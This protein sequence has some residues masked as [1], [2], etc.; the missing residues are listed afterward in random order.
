MR[1]YYI[2]ISA[3]VL[4]FF[5]LIFLSQSANAG[6]STQEDILTHGRYIATIAGC[7]SCHTPDKA[8]YQNPK[9]LTPEMIQTL[10]FDGENAIDPQKFL[11]GGRL[12]DLGPAGVV[13]SRNLTSDDTTGT[14]KWTDEQIKIAIKT[15]L[16]ADGKTLFPVMPYHVFTGMADDD[17]TAVVAFIRSVNAVNN[18]V[19]KDTVKT[20]GL[21]TLP[22]KK[23]I[24]APDPS[25][26]AAR[27]AYLV[28]N[29]MACNDCHTP[30]DPATGAP[31]AEKYLAGGQP[32]EGPWGIVYGGN[33]TPDPKTGLGDW[34][35]EQIK[36]TFT[37]GIRKDGRRLILL[38]WYAYQSL[39]PQ[40]ADA[41]AYYLKHVLPA[42][43]NEVPAASLKPG[44]SVMTPGA[45]AAKN[46]QGSPLLIWIIIG[47]LIITLAGLA[48]YYY[49][50]RT[51]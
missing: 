28:N 22:Y 31:I 24:I 46:N 18:K 33:I 45:L 14:G 32:Y 51:G 12:F 25:D 49:R 40:D 48:V 21:P 42:V 26:K 5:S 47:V 9:T 29:V 11:A 27:G 35:E 34:T 20:D 10:A 23:G 2:F 41:V 50:R 30:L 15:G 37:S 17:V 43:Y 36:N 44:F 4:A 7:S 39:S 1:N 38:P 13:Y 19:P 16:A 3:F 8:E 6:K